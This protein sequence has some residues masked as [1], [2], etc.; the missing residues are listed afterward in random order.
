M[1]CGRDSGATEPTQPEIIVLARGTGEAVT[2]QSTIITQHAATDWTNSKDQ[3][4]WKT[5]K[6]DTISM[7]S[8]PA[9]AG[10]VGVPMG[11]RVVIL[12]PGAKVGEPAAAFVMDL[13]RLA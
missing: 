8:S 5:G 6:P 12:L 2:A 11:S 9:L 13:D 7:A 4:T 3:S 1:G 10:L